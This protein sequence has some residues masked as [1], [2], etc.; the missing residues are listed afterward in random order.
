MCELTMYRERG[1]IDELGKCTRFGGLPDAVLTAL[2]IAE[3][4]PDMTTDERIAAIMALRPV[5]ISESP[6][7]VLRQV[8]EICEAIRR[9]RMES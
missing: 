8:N 5:Q 1:L 3:C 9:G 6:G 7:G 2:V 4:N